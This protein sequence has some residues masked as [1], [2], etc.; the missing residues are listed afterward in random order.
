[1]TV[2]ADHSKYFEK[3]FDMMYM[4]NY[5]LVT[6]PSWTWQRITEMRNAR[7]TWVALCVIPNVEDQICDQWFAGCASVCEI[8]LQRVDASFKTKSC[9]MAPK[10]WRYLCRK[11][12][13][14]LRPRSKTSWWRIWLCENS[15]RVLRKIVAFSSE[16]CG[17]LLN[18]CTR[19]QLVLSCGGS[20]IM[21]MCQ[22]REGSEPV[23]VHCR[24]VSV[25][26]YW[27][28]KALIHN[29]SVIKIRRVI[30]CQNADDVVT[31]TH[32]WRI[33]CL[34]PFWSLSCCTCSGLEKV[35]LLWCACDDKKTWIDK[36]DEN[37]LS[38]VR[39]IR[40]RLQLTC[41]DDWYHVDKDYWKLEKSDS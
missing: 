38:S 41:G 21:A 8:P 30:R 37:Y 11:A 20:E 28:W 27:R 39:T 16:N 14:R 23:A 4:Q 2:G 33:S 10:I 19:N 18:S 26:T 1:M 36:G 5:G 22:T 15:D 17:S 12:E 35:F 9:I 40:I 25:F 34:D 3:M 6:S 7:E 31:H 32:Y 29:R 13:R 24:I